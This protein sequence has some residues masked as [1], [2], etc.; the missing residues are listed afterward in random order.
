MT[1]KKVFHNQERIRKIG[2]GE[3]INEQRRR[4]DILDNLISYFD[5]GRSKSFFCQTCT[6]LS[7]ESLD[8]NIHESK[9]INNSLDI[10]EKNKVIREMIL[11]IADGSEIDLKLKKQ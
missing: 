3:F 9:M 8:K 4:I 10:K 2:L 1:H 5:N 7:I 11:E 6:L